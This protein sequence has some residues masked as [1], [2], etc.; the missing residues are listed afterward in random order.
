MATIFNKIFVTKAEYSIIKTMQSSEQL[1]WLFDTYDSTTKQTGAMDLSAF[2]KDVKD[3]LEQY[4]NSL[5]MHV[6]EIDINQNALPA[7]SNIDFVD[8]MIDD[9]NIMIESNSLKAL[10]HV[11]DKFIE[12]GY[13]LQ[14]DLATEKMFR[15]DKTTRYI[16]VF[17]IINY[18]SSMCLN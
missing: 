17:R 1:K 15:K 8:V 16:R 14:R 4:N 3:E 9:E 11:K 13:M 12:S 2:F 5:P 18:T 6:E 7:D 10:R